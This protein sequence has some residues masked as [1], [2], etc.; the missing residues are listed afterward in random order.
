MIYVRHVPQHN[1]ADKL[2]AALRAETTPLEF[3]A[4]AD[5]P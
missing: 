4:A 1:A 5:A 3:T 2:S